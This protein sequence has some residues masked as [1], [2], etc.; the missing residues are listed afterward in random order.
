[1]NKSGL[2]DRVADRIGVSRSVAVEA[3]E[4]VFEAVGEALARGEEVRMVG[5]GTFG[6]RNRPARTGRNPRTGERVEIPRLDHSDVQTRQAVAGH[7]ECWCRAVKQLLP[8]W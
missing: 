8:N 6:I 3:V 7:C 4:A 1:M 5:F 2:A